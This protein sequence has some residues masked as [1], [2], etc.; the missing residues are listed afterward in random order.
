MPT[1]YTR[2]DAY[3]NITGYAFGDPWVAEALFMDDWVY[4][5]EEEAAAAWGRY[6]ANQNDY[7]E[8]DQMILMTDKQFERE[9][10]MAREDVYRRESQERQ[11]VDV[12]RRIDE[13]WRAIEDI[14]AM[15]GQ[16][17]RTPVNDDLVVPTSNLH[18]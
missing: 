18:R 1:M 14:R 17:N 6:L 13:I 11:F 2:R 3:G 9:L 5:T 15:M 7:K 4:K 12:H 10:A 16:T 8:E